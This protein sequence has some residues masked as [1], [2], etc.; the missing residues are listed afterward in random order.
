KKRVPIQ[1][2]ALINS[3]VVISC[4][5]GLFAPVLPCLIVY[6]APGTPDGLCETEIRDTNCATTFSIVLFSVNTSKEGY[7]TAT[8]CKDLT[9]NSLLIGTI[10]ATPNLT[11]PSGFLR[12]DELIR[13]IVWPLASGPNTECVKVNSSSG[14]TGASTL[15]TGSLV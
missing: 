2:A 10:T 13:Q 1:N 8:A 4:V 9:L 5:Q 6:G 12:F 7:P 11:P 15:I 14:V 3:S